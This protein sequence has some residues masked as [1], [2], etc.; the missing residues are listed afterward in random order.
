MEKY[1]MAFS[2][3]GNEDIRVA[4]LI[5]EQGLKWLCEKGAEPPHENACAQFR[6]TR[7]N[8]NKIL[9]NTIFNVS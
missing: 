5:V 2:I 1:V 9:L 8:L 6:Y 4:H 3:W 7:F